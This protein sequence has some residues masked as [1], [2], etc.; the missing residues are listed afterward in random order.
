MNCAI[1]L[2]RD[3]ITVTGKRVNSAP[4]LCST[5]NIVYLVQCQLCHKCYIGRT[6]NTLRNR[7]GQHRTHFYEIVDGKNVD[8]SKDDDYSL[9]FH[10]SHDHNLKC[11]EDF[12]NTYKV[13]IVDNCSPKLLEYK[14]HKFIHLLKTLRPLGIN[15]VNPFG[16]NLLH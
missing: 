11:R 9:G 10:L 16:L 8:F 6:I 7:I 1:V 2:D 4:G 14:E 13:F 12:N 5:Y 3:H 15:T